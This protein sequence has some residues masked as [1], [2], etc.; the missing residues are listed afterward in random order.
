MAELIEAAV[1]C[2]ER[3]LAE[4][5]LERLAETTRASGTDV[6][7]RGRRRLAR[8]AERRRRRRRASTARRSTGWGARACRV[9]LAR[10]HLLY[11]EWLRRERRRLDARDQLRTAHEMFTSMGTEAFAGRA[12]R[13]LLATG[14][15]R[16]QT[17]RRDPRGAHR[18]GDPD[19]A[20]RPRRPVERR[21]RRARCS[22]ASTRSPTTCARSSPSSTSPRATSSA[23]SCPGAPIQRRRRN[24]HHTFSRLRT[25][26][27]PGT[28]KAIRSA[29][30]RSDALSTAPR[31]VTSPPST[32]TSMP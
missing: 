27:T 1:R 10:A 2:G 26:D 32:S 18:P 3:A 11:G 28:R 21:D 14:R 29:P 31:S 6:G 22:S 9:Q 25:S 19:R 12:E 8:A 4:R 5:A 23:E 7:A 30:S 17:Q 15:A 16:P 13:E 20:A 24:R